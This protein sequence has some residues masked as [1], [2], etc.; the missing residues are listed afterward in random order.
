[1]KLIYLLTIVV[2]ITSSFELQQIHDEIITETLVFAVKHIK[3]QAY[4]TFHIGFSS[5]SYQSAY[6]QASIING[7]LLKSDQDLVVRLDDF[8]GNQYV[9]NE[10]RKFTMLLIDSIESFQAIE[11]ILKSR[12]YH[13]DGKHLIVISQSLEK[14]ETLA[15]IQNVFDSLFERFI[16]NVELIVRNATTGL[17]DFYTFF[18]VSSSYCFNVI[19]SLHNT[20]DGSHTLKPLN[21][22]PRKFVNFFGCP[23][24]LTTFDFPPHV[25]MSRENGKVKVRGLDISILNGVAWKLNFSIQVIDTGVRG[26][27]LPN[28]TLTGTLAVLKNAEA[29]ITL[30]GFSSTS[31]AML[32]FSPSIAFHYTSMVFAIPQLREYS[33]LEK[34]ILPFGYDVWIGIEVIFGLTFLASI[35]LEYFSKPLRDLVFGDTVKNPVFEMIAVYLGL[36]IVRFPKKALARNVVLQWLIASLILSSCYKA[37]LFGML[38]TGFLK[39]YPSTIEGMLNLGFVIDVPLPLMQNLRDGPLGGK[40][41]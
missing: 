31:K 39:K 12:Q 8:G 10:R 32:Q 37:I 24:V 6:Q 26:I 20:F 1:M 5:K 7:F 15:L 38:K 11:S 23:L 18:P 27:M 35:S 25:F 14:D 9:P 29:N 34:L 13:T 16:V 30:G 21:L 4:T 19:P 40:K 2:A 22:F 17:V 41:E 3:I 33:P 28:G 36:A